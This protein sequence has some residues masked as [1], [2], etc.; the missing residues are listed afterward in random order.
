MKKFNMK[1]ICGTIYVECDL[2]FDHSS[3]VITCYRCGHTVCNVCFYM[4]EKCVCVIC[5]SN[6]VEPFQNK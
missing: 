6:F 3:N 2:C 4:K 5:G 1:R